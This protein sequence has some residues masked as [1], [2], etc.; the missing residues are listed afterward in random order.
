MLLCEGRMTA[1]P[2]D[3]DRPPDAD[4]ETLTALVYVVLD[5]LSKVE[6]TVALLA[7]SAGID[8]PPPLPCDWST[9][10]STAHTL[11]CSVSNVYRLI[12]LRVL[13]AEKHAGR[14]L[15]TAESIKKRRE[16]IAVR[17]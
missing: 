16:R 6:E 5:R 8:A 10:K 11:D 14:V 17:S 12:R 3:A 1:L 7:L 9:V 13:T 4:I 2:K 15:V